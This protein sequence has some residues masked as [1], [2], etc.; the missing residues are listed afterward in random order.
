MTLRRRDFITLVCGA[1]AWPAATRAQPRLPVVG[2]LNSGFE[3]AIANQLAGF[4]KG[5]SEAGYAEG[6]NVAIEFR[7]AE[8][9][10]DRFPALAADL[11]RR[12]VAVIFVSSPAGARAAAAATATIPIVFI[13]GEDPVKEGL[14]AGLNRPGGNVTGVSFFANQLAGKMLGLL[15]DTVPKTALFALLVNP[16]HPNVESDTKDAQVAAD[17]LGQGLRVLSASSEPELQTAFTTMVQLRVGGLFVNTDPFFDSRLEQLVALA[18]RNRIPAIYIRRDYPAAGGLMSYGASAIDAY[19]EAGIYTG[20]ILR[21]EKPADMPVMRPTKFELVIN[22]KT[23]KALGL[24]VPPNLLA[25]ADE[26]IE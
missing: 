5:L 18:A 4:R 16:T 1:A 9:Q 10:Y 19:R 20:R 3:S 15:R 6:R 8:T 24:T 14:V 22:L 25:T 2:F 17:A 12:Q 26:V 11:V 7:W 23:A 21:G 13:M